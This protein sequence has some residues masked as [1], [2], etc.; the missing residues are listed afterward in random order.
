MHNILIIVEPAEG[1]FNP[2]VPIIKKFVERGHIVL[3]LTGR[4]YRD[5]VESLGAGFIP[6][7]AQWDVGDQ[8]VYDFFPA[9]K[10]LKGLAQ[11]KFYIK[12][13][14]YDQ[15]PDILKALESVLADFKADVI[16]GDSFMVAGTWLR[17]LGGPP[18]VRLSVLPL[19]LPGKDL[20]PFG[21]G[22]MPGSTYFS[23]L[24]NNLLHGLF[25]K[26]LFKDVQQH[27]NQLRHKVGL[28]AYDKY[29]FISAVES[30]DLVLHT[31][32]PVFEYPRP[33]FPANFRFIG[34]VVLPPKSDFQ[35][36]D[37]WQ[38][39]EHSRDKPVILVNQG[40]VARDCNDLIVPAVDALKHENVWVVAVPVTENADV[41]SLGNL[42]TAPYIPF[43]NLL[44]LV[45]VMVT[46]GGFGAV[47]NAL[48]HGIPL[49]IA[50][51]TEDKMEVAARVEYAGAGINLKTK[52]PTAAEIRTAVMKILSDPSFK[53][54][55]L[56]LKNDFQ[57]YDAPALA[58]EFVEE[59]LTRSSH[60]DS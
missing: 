59:L 33:T 36:P 15:V 22:L 9:L 18:S 56:K 38:E 41:A 25:E 17:E 20:A 31:S 13:V 43:G 12:H 37:W 34:P 19:S 7:P 4:V 24:R 26:V 11:I 47:Q 3:C 45:D 46:N 39:I 8:E 23:K 21:L 35:P 28:P 58:L 5:R 44:P 53:H 60:A 40:T 57:Q 14:M 6:L 29:L 10:S 2:F 55:A 30:P 51:A 50:G 42:R 48:A 52:Q 54:N 1:H 32:T 16:M 49:V 27:V